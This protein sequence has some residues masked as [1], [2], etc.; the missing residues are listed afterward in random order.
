MI[1]GLVTLKHMS[2]AALGASLKLITH[3]RVKTQSRGSCLHLGAILVGTLPLAH[4]SCSCPV[5]NWSALI[6]VRMVPGT[7]QGLDFCATVG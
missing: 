1:A 3:L 6:N 2:N 4:F 7:T 5:L